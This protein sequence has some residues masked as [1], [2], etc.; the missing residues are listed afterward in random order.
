MKRRRPHRHTRRTKSGKIILVN[1]NVPKVIIQPQERLIFKH[2]SNPKVYNKEY[3]GAID[4]D[5]KGKIENINV[6]PGNMYDIDLP[7]DFEVLYHTHPDKLT[8]PPTPDDILALIRSNH[9][10]AE[11]VFRDGGSFS[12]VK[13]PKV[14]ELKDLSDN[15]LKQVI[16]KLY[17][18]SLDA[19]DMETNYKKQLEELGF[20]V[21]VNNNITQPV[22]LP[23]K[24]IEPRGKNATRS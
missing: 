16:G 10:Q 8:S 18:K 21:Q 15:K 14:K 17:V 9:Q 1:R 5:K 7:T 22:I 2:L 13:T 11:I 23:I 12:V 20:F 4:F 24:P 19:K 3:G 6:T